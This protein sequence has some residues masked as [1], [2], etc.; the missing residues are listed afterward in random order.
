M[1][2]RTREEFSKIQDKNFASGLLNKY[3]R[4]GQGTGIENTVTVR[5][6]YANCFL[7]ISIQIELL[8]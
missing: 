5:T 8:P 2:F 7:K 3:P 1:F 6:S 4:S